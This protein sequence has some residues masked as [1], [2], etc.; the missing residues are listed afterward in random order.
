MNGKPQ[1]VPQIPAGLGAASPCAQP[2]SQRRGRAS[3][4]DLERAID[5]FVAARRG[6]PAAE[7]PWGPRPRIARKG[8]S[9]LEV[10]RALGH[11]PA[12]WGL[13][14]VFAMLG[15]LN[16]DWHGSTGATKIITNLIWWGI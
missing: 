11:S 16:V 2:P 8:R 4:G 12:A 15:L 6:T 5:Q 1:I 9:A 3:G 7:P 10:V 13:S 14:I